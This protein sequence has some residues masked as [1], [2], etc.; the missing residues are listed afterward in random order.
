MSNTIKNYY[1]VILIEN[2][3]EEISVILNYYN[4]IKQVLRPISCVPRK[5]Q[6][7]IDIFCI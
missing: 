3:N 5:T 1:F 7:I 4:N 6:Y 2:T